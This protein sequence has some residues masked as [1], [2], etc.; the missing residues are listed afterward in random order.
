MS[1]WRRS[2]APAVSSA[3]VCASDASRND[4]DDDDD[5][6]AGFGGRAAAVGALLVDSG[7]SE[8]WTCA[9]LSNTAG[10]Y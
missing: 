3:L 8:W 5:D 4:D 7:R 9:E 10:A 6:D 2:C 1:V